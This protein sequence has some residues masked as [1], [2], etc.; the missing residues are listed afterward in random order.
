MLGA[1]CTALGARAGRAF[2]WPPPSCRPK[3]CRR[4]PARAHLDLARQQVLGHKPHRDSSSGRWTTG[5][6]SSPKTAIAFSAMGA[7]PVVAYHAWELAESDR[8]VDPAPELCAGKLRTSGLG[9]HTPSCPAPLPRA[10][11]RLSGLFPLRRG[12]WSWPCSARA[13]GDSREGAC[14]SCFC[15]SRW[16][17]TGLQGP[18]SSSQR[19]SWRSRSFGALLPA[20]AAAW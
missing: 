17:A 16:L 3:Q 5:G 15:R 11:H 18:K 12:A 20:A 13:G 7:L 1:H 6:Q 10:P 19:A 14:R 2:P 9:T 8:I 4:V